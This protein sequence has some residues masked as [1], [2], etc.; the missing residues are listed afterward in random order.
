MTKLIGKDKT[1]LYFKSMGYD[2]EEPYAT[3]LEKQR[4][5]D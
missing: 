4:K 3:W 2:P 1:K 5:M